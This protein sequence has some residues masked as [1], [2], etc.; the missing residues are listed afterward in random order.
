M[1]FRLEEADELDNTGMIDA[2]HDL[3]L[4]EDVGALEERQDQLRLEVHNRDV[5]ERV[6]QGGQNC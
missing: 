5:P 3:D 2:T 6:E 1:F 4:F